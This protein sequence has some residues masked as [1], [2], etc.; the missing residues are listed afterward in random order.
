MECGAVM[1]RRE[2]VHEQVSAL[3][4]D[5]ISTEQFMPV[6]QQYIYIFYLAFKEI[7]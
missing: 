7:T 4:S 5:L 2:K 1:G 6:S 3:S